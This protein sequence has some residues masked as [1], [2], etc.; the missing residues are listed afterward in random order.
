MK[1]VFICG[2]GVGIGFM[3]FI[4]NVGHSAGGAFVGF[5]VMAALGGVAIW[6]IK[7]PQEDK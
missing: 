7:H 6:G 2:I 1:E 4:D 5:V 3:I